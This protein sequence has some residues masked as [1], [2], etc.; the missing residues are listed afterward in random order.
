MQIFDYNCVSIIIINDY[1][2]LVQAAYI[3]Y[4]IDKRNLQSEHYLE[5]EKVSMK[6]ID[7]I[8]CLE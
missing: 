3:E 4:D 7:N 6:N 5:K 2:N 1:D 8:I